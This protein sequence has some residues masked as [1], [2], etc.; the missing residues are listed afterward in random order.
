MDLNPCNYP[1]ELLFFIL[2]TATG[3]A[4]FVYSISHYFMPEFVDSLKQLRS[5]HVLRKGW[6][7]YKRWK[8]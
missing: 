8:G 7:D 4:L 3:M 1:P 2:G 5:S 6:E